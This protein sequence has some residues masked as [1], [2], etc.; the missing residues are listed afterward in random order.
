MKFGKNDNP[1]DES[2]LF[3]C[4]K[5]PIMMSSPSFKLTIEFLKMKTKQILS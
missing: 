2:M 1:D 4:V 5:P 3:C